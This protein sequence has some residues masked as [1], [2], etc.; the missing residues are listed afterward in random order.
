MRYF[1][2]FFLLLLAA[3]GFLHSASAQTDQF[4]KDQKALLKEALRV[5]LETEKN[6]P[7]YQDLT[8]KKKVILLDNMFSVDDYFKAPI[9]I[10]KKVMP[11]LDDVELE[12]KTETELKNI[13]QKEDLMFVRV[14]QINPPQTEYG[15]VHVFGQWHLGEESRAKGYVFK[16]ADAYTLLFKKEKGKWKYQKVINR[17]PNFIEQRMAEIEEDRLKAQEK[18][19][20]EDKIKVKV[21]VK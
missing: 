1:P 17:F 3:I 2:K 6:L 8:D 10:T 11:K 14:G 18:A 13:K 7:N 15:M 9:F 12:L 4:S 19:K 16:Q 20:E 5:A 21:K